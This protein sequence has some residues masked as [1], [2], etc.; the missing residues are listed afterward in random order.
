MNAFETSITIDLAAVVLAVGTA[1]GALIGGWATRRKVNADA[2]KVTADAHKVETDAENVALNAATGMIRR[3]ETEVRKMSFR[4]D[5]L[6]EELGVERARSETP[7]GSILRRLI[8]LLNSSA[9]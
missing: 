8:E 3:L 4:I 2:A 1:G 6:E 7:G 5:S 9:K